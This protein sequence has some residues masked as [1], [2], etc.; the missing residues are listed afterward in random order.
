MNDRG[1]DELSDRGAGIHNGRCSCTGLSRDLLGGRAHQNGE[2]RRAGAASKEDPLRNPHADSAVHEWR[3]GKSEG[4]H[5]NRRKQHVART[6]TVCNRS[7]NRLREAP[8]KLTNRQRQA[9]GHHAQSG[10][11]VHRPHEQTEGLPSAHRDHQ[12]ASRRQ[13]NGQDARRLK[14]LEHE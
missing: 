6:P 1:Q 12:N 4:R 10:R 7:R 2:T 13:N 5:H 8:D 3:Q 9:E 11:R 14:S